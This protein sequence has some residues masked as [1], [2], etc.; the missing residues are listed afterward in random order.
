MA[1]Y[2]RSNISHSM[3]RTWLLLLP[4]KAVVDLLLLQARCVVIQLAMNRSRRMSVVFNFDGSS[5]Y[6][7]LFNSRRSFCFGKFLVGCGSSV[8][9]QGL[10]FCLMV[11]FNIDYIF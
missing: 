1:V 2:L 9:W 11:D 8:F 6:V 7:T 10:Q 5:A 4:V 3:D